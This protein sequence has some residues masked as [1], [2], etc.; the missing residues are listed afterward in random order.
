VATLAGVTPKLPAHLNGPKPIGG[1]YTFGGRK[2]RISA[3][4]QRA[5]DELVPLYLARP[6]FPRDQPII[7]EIGC[8]KGDATA[9]MA[10]AEPE[11][12]VIACE[13]N[14]AALANLALLIEEN[15]LE[16][17]RLWL[18]DGF[19]VLTELGREAVTEIR[20]W[21]PDPWPKPRHAHKRLVTPER[22]M[23]ITDSLV[24]GG[25]L[26]LATDDERYAAEALDSIKAEARLNGRVVPRPAE[27]P[28]TTFE[29]RGHREGRH[30]IDIEAHRTA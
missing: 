26:R 14:G 15:E 8:G 13:A 17:V 6:P 11:S 5:L 10:L 16:N 2:G 18:G 20:V 1:S 12:F 27:R 22:L 4:R 30:A 7:V 28:I 24:V 21:F 29:A 23:V 25:K 3:A 19:S 9:A